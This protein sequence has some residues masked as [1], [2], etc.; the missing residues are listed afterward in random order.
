MF[1]LS[2]QECSSFFGSALGSTEEIQ[3]KTYT[4]KLPS[5]LSLESSSNHSWPSEEIFK[6][7]DT[8]VY[9]ETNPREASLHTEFETN[10]FPYDGKI[11]STSSSIL[12]DESEFNSVGSQKELIW[13]DQSNEVLSGQLHRSNDSSSCLEDIEGVRKR[14]EK[15]KRRSSTKNLRLEGTCET[16]RVRN[17]IA[18]RRYRERRQKEVEILDKKVKELEQDLNTAKMETKW[19]QMEAQRWQELAEKREKK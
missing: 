6:E 11:S 13:I 10:V 7:G 19:W 14:V 18:A 17:T 16:K 3:N 4:P 9:P 5:E 12:E 15:R 1:Q 8:P 2:P